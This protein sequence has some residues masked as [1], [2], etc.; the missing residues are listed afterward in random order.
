MRRIGGL[1][2]VVALFAG[3]CTPKM[4]AQR[5][6]GK[7]ERVFSTCRKLTEEAGVRPGEHS[8]AKVASLAV[9]A[10]LRDTG[11]DAAEWKPMLAAWLAE[12]SFTPYYIDSSAVLPGPAPTLPNP[13][14]VATTPAGTAGPAGGAARPLPSAK[15]SATAVNAPSRDAGPPAPKKAAYAAGAKV[16]VLWQGKWWPASVLSVKADKYL[17]HYDGWSS[18]WDEWVTTARMKQR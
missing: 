2:L 16:A 9:E 14:P 3:G 1:L 15:P 6:L 7:Y 10:S 5:L 13:E 12:T 8:C 18:T 17:I 11:L 4:R